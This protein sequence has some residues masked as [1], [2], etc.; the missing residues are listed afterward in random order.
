[1]MPPNAQPRI[2]LLK[3]RDVAE[4][5][6]ISASSVYAL[7]EAGRIACHRIGIG[8][9]AIRI[10]ERDLDAFLDACRTSPRSSPRRKQPQ[11]ILKHLK[12]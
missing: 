4:R 10:D 3:V 11:P 8:R 6:A 12:I 7:V 2:S 9:G 1:M 5:L